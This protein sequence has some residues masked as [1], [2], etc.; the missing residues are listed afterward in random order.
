MAVNGMDVEVIREMILPGCRNRIKIAFQEQT[1][2]SI[3]FRLLY[4]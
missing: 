4:Y 2:E 3:S 1:K